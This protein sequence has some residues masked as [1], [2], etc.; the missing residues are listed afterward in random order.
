L[1]NDCASLME[2]GGYVNAGNLK[3]LSIHKSLNSQEF[4]KTLHRAPD[5]ICRMRNGKLLEA[6]ARKWQKA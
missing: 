1:S 5:L 3:C 6:E 2:P 4:A